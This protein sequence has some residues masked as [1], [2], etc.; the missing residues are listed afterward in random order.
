MSFGKDPQLHETL[1]SLAILG[2]SYLAARLLSFLFGRILA[3]A[4]QDTVNTLDD[5]LVLAIQRPIT[6]ALFLIG[7]YAAIHRAP[8]PDLWGRRIDATLF[9]VSVL[10]V[11][12]ALIRGYA[13][14]IE[15]YTS[16][17]H[18]AGSGAAAF[19]PLLSKIGRAVIALVS[20][21]TIL[22][23]LGVNV[24]SLVVSLGVGSLAI[25]LAAQDTLANLFAGFTLTLDQ[26]FAIGDRIQLATGEVGDVEAIGVRSTRLRTP[27]ET[28]LIVPNSVLVKDRLVNL[29][30]PTRRLAVRIDLNVPYGTDLAQAKSL[31]AA[32][33][34][35]S[36]FVHAESPPAVVV[37]QLGDSGVSLRLAFQATDYTQA[38]LARSEVCEA[39]YK[40][41]LAAGI[42]TPS[43]ALRIL[44]AALPKP[45]EP[46]A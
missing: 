33:A 17:A 28:V 20:M 7:A 13:I 6:Y 32:A 40:S 30:R 41:F 12:L 23:Y 39:V 26:P 15:W 37:T 21:I 2:G 34:G 45:G 1:V 4:A 35:G 36:P 43:P 10:F 27:D 14:F 46:K 25:G 9:V 11:T 24:A 19:G 29:S 18:G 44:S 31:L 38:H 22:Q 5:R 42:E 3:R 8:L 16:H